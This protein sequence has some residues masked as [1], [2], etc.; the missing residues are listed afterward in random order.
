MA[1]LCRRTFIEVLRNSTENR[2]GLF[3]QTSRLCSTSINRYD[4]KDPAPYFFNPKVQEVLQKVTGMNFEKIFIRKKEGK[5]LKVPKYEFLT[6]EELQEKLQVARF[7]AEKLLQMPPILKVRSPIE[8]VLSHDPALKGYDTAKYVFTDITPNIRDRDRFIAVRDAEGTLR[9]ATWEERDRINQ[10]Y[11]PQPGKK[12]G[13]PRMFIDENLK[14]VLSREK[15]E[16]ILDR[17]CVQYAPDDPEYQRVTSLTYE[18]IESRRSFDVL[19]STRHYGPFCFY[20]AWNKKLD[21]L[22]IYLIQEERLSDAVAIVQLFQLLHPACKSAALNMDPENHIGY[23]KAY[24]ETDCLRQAQLQLALQSY[25]E[26]V[27][28]RIIYEKSIQAAHGNL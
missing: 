15:Y 23:I 19:L 20:L 2:N 10:I 16:F 26:L 8:K 18:T 9:C 22:I 6:D 4:D 11:N 3:F 24:M 13:Q 27:Q 7:K 28:E 25:Q 21:N 12:M 5:E 14:E 17:A 1:G